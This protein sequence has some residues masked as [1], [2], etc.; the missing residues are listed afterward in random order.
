MRHVGVLLLI[1][2]FSDTVTA[3]GF[4][5]KFQEWL[6]GDLAQVDNEAQH[7]SELDDASKGCLRCH[8]GSRATRV[9]AK[10]A[11]S[12]L[13]FKGARNMNH[14]VGMNYN[15]FAG[16]HAG[17]Y[18]PLSSLDPAIHLVGGKVSCIS[19]HKRK[20]VMRDQPQ[21]FIKFVL[22]DEQSNLICNATNELTVGP[23]TTDLCKACHLKHIK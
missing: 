8:D 11:E 7:L 17:T 12:P 14:P 13:Q 5:D 3:A 2:L 15:T 16:K 9:T 4:G 6:L 22:H 21:G 10:S 19:C 20:K 1:M 23:T 18:R